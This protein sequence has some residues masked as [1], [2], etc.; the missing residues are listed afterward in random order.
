[1]IKLF[2]PFNLLLDEINEGEV[3]IVEYN[4]AANV[5]LLP[6]QFL[7]FEDSVLIVMGDR[8]SLKLLSLLKVLKE[9]IEIRG[10]I[11]LISNNP[12]EFEGFEISTIKPVTLNTILSEIYGFIKDRG[13]DDGVVV[14]WGTEQM[15]LYVD[16]SDAIKEF[17]KLKSSMPGMTVVEFIN[18]EAVDEKDLAIIESAATTIFRLEGKLSERGIERRIAILKSINPIKK[19]VAEFEPWNLGLR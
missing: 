3:V 14:I 18:F 5:D 17:A 19:E 15:G 12:I 13:L 8:L 10:S 16:L 1:L 9:K 11:I 6:F 4:T 7:E 2:H